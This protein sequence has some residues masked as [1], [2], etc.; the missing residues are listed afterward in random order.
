MDTEVCM[1]NLKVGDHLGCL[2]VGGRIIFDWIWCS[3]L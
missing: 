3:H 2:G 1:E